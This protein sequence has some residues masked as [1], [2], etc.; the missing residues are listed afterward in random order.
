MNLQVG[1]E[2]NNESPDG[3]R[4]PKLNLECDSERDELFFIIK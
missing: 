4:D 1:K 2:S 3:K